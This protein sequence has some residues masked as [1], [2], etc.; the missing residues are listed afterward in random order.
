[1]ELYGLLLHRIQARLPAFGLVW[2]GPECKGT[3]IPLNRERRR[4]DRLL[5]EA[6]AMTGSDSPPRLMLNDHCTV[7]E[8]R[9]NCAEEAQ[10]RDDLSLLRGMSEEEVK[11][12]GKRGIFTVTQLSCTFRPRRTT[13]RALANGPPHSHALQALAIRENN[14]RA[15]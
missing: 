9:R 4:A 10:A 15:P 7:C 3:R 2:H 13:R 8:F 14:R 6:E 12:Y 11:K 5:R 1:L